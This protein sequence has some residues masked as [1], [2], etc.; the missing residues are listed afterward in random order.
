M[1]TDEVHQA[2]GSAEI[3]SR[4]AR[5]LADME[6]MLDLIR[7]EQLPHSKPHPPSRAPRGIDVPAWLVRG[8]DLGHDDARCLACWALNHL[9]G[10]SG[11]HPRLVADELIHSLAGAGGLPLRVLLAIHEQARPYATFAARRGISVSPDQ[12][13]YTDSYAARASAR[14]RLIDIGLRCIP[15]L[16][17]PDSQRIRRAIGTLKELG[18]LAVETQKGRGHSNL[19]IPHRFQPVTIPIGL[20]ENGWLSESG[21]TQ[22]RRMPAQSGGPALVLL[23]QLITLSTNT[24]DEYVGVD[25]LQ[26]PFPAGVLA[27]SLNLLL[28]RGLI[29][30]RRKSVR[31]SRRPRGEPLPRADETLKSKVS[32]AVLDPDLAHMAF[33]DDPIRADSKKRKR[34]TRDR[35]RLSLAEVRAEMAV[36][37]RRIAAERETSER[38]HASFAA[39]LEAAQVAI[40]GNFPEDVE[41]V[42]Y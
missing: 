7:L 29:S 4:D 39:T 11:D 19:Y 37:A 13:A 23:L 17:K 41:I 3:S 1:N 34:D 20:W 26:F 28:E 36:K 22:A 8:G 5:L 40:M 27:S 30:I 42:V 33:H 35:S 31:A 15:S 9:P 6:G 25:E 10:V 24:K 32:I 2:G 14:M 18:L 12:S 16:D 38:Q 21:T